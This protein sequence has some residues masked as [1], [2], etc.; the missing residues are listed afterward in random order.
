MPEIGTL[1]T[2]KSRVLLLPESSWLHT[3]AL[4]LDREKK[5]AA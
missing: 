2:L 4:A 5:A 3:A 1:A